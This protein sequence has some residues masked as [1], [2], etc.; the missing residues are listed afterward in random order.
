MSYKTICLVIP[1]FGKLPACFVYWLESVRRNPTIDFLL[2][3]DDHY[4]YDYPSNVRVEYATFNEVRDRIQNKFSLPVVI[5]APYKLCD[6]KPAYGIIFSDF[7]AD[8]D[9]WG[10]CD[11]DLIFGDIRKFLTDEILE[12]YDR[13]LSRG[14]LT[15]YRNSEEVSTRFLNRSVPGVDWTKALTSTGSFAFD[16]RPMTG[17]MWNALWPEKLYDEDILADVSWEYSNFQCIDKILMGYWGG[18]F[19][20]TYKTYNYFEYDNGHLYG[21]SEESSGSLSRREFCYA[22]FQKRALLPLAKNFDRY[23]IADN[24]FLPYRVVSRKEIRL[25][26]MKKLVYLPYIRIRL[27]NLKRKIFRLFK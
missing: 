21:V 5:D 17:R 2:I 25:W 23:I 1:Y 7:L 18:E 6:Y 19:K 22:H 8:Y 4:A 12:E 24:A 26:G 16:E 10:H 14:H 20:A 11:C 9:F 13:I 3:T 15:V 27:G